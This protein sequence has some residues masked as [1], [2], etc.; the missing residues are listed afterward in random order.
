[1]NEKKTT[2]KQLLKT[3][4]W[5][6]SRHK[7][8]SY[9]ALCDIYEKLDKLEFDS[10]KRYTQMAT[11]IS[12]LSEIKWFLVSILAVLIFMAAFTVFVQAAELTPEASIVYPYVDEVSDSYGVSTGLIMAVIEKES[13]YE[14][15]V[16][17]G[18]CVGLMQINPNFQKE[19]MER[20][21]CT[22]LYDWKQ[23]VLVGTDYIFELFETY[24]D[25][26]LVLMVY[27]MKYDS[28][29]NQYAKGNISGY[30][31]KVLNRAYE[32]DSFFES[33]GGSYATF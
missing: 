13:M 25:P 19:R 24:E 18:R 2:K 15:D 5:D 27:N 30:A 3:L 8:H 4:E 17:N 9:E 28:A 1:M 32:L 14:P 10:G 6:L 33:G 31:K 22:D 21:G 11:M 7:E 12:I 26:A 16:S 29:M 20:L 23:N